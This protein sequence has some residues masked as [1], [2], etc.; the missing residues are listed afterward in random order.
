MNWRKRRRISAVLLLLALLFRAY[1][2]VGFMPSAGSFALEICP[3][4][5]PVA[6]HAHHH[7]DSHPASHGAHLAFQHCPFGAVPGAAPALHLALA[8]PGPEALPAPPLVQPL[9]VPA[10]RLERAHA[11]RAPPFLA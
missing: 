10:E 6:P 8:L 11:A 2:P 4:G 7:D 9:A 1:V 5:L 3:D